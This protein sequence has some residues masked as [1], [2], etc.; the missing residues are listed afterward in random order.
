MLLFLIMMLLLK[1]MMVVVVVMMMMMMMMMMTL[2]LSSLTLAFTG[3]QDHDAQI[4][5]QPGECVA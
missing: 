3:L 2:K 1:M 4:C 5:G